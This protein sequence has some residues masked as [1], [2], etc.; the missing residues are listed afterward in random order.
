[1]KLD[2]QAKQR[3]LAITEEIVTNR[4]VKGEV[5]PDNDADL[6]QACRQ[7][8]RDARALYLAALDFV[9]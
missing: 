6:R 8:A 4:V 5:D 3:I 1:M 2:E 7:A 9:S